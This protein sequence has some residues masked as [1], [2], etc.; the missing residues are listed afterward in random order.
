MGNYGKLRILTVNCT[1][2]SDSES[3]SETSS[4]SESDSE[5]NGAGSLVPGFNAMIASGALLLVGAAL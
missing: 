2:S 1:G 5:S 3:E 4:E